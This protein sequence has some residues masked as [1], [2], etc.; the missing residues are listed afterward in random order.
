VAV[1]NPV[2]LRPYR[3]FSEVEQP[4]SQFVFRMKTGGSSP[5]CALFN[6]DGGAWA[7]EAIENIKRWLSDRLPEWDILA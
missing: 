5:S 6:A 2:T 1:P 3:T 4:A 7:L